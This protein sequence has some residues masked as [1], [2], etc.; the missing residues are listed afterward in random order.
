MWL[1]LKKL[2]QQAFKSLDKLSELIDEV[3]KTATKNAVRPICACNYI[4]DSFWTK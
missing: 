3:Y 1:T 4:F 2:L